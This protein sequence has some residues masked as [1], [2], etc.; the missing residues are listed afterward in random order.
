MNP[1]SNAT[2]GFLI[3]LAIF[4]PPAGDGQT[5]SLATHLPRESVADLIGKLNPNQKQEFNDAGKAYGEKR[6]AD[7]L[8]LHK[9]LLNDFPGDP[10]LL[11]FA[12]EAALMGGNS[13]FATNALKPIAQA[14]PDD[15]QAAVLLVRAC[16]E[17]GDLSCRDT[18]IAHIRDLQSRGVIPT[19]L[20]EYAVED[21]KLSE[22]TLL[23]KVSVV[24]W[25]NYKVYTVGNVRDENGKL[26][27]T[28]SL[29]SSDFDQM[30]FAREHPSE[31]ANG[32]RLFSLDAYQETG[33]NGNGQRTQTHYTYKFFTGQ[34][35][36]STIRQEFIDVAS[37][38]S[39][40]LSSRSGLVVP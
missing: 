11:K 24:P 39:R 16:A 18:Q 8:A 14:D 40:P 4:L 19:Q 3:A 34:P 31:A 10:I 1:C 7:S 28:I 37:A 38:K 22:R 17:S 26:L 27:L 13:G 35:D 33:L 5:G 21:I 2:A 15:W 30:A 20:R 9:Q 23:I 29:E 32:V 6:Y 25:G 36:Y 12:S